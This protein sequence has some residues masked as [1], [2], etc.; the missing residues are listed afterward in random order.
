MSVD[1]EK[2]IEQLG[3]SYKDI[4]K[5]GLIPYKT[6]PYGSVSDDT[7]SLEMKREGIYLSFFND[8]DKKL[9]EVMLRLED[10]EKTDWLFPNP[11]PFGLGLVMTQFWVREHFGLPM[12]YSDEKKI[13]SFYI[14]KKEV[15]ALP[16]PH[17]NIAAMFT[18]NKNLFAEHVIF[19]SLNH[20]KKIQSDLEI[21]KLNEK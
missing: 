19:F 15:Y 16:A 10:E 5:E 3:K 21:K 2:L 18:Y 6:K 12:I 20:A 14:G 9:K 17:Q 4:F 13:M 1:V 8:S 11:M 7:A